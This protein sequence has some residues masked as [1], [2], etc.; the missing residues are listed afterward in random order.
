[1]D[2]IPK[3]M[4]SWKLE[5]VEWKHTTLKKEIIK[6]AILELKQ[7]WGG[8]SKDILIGSTSL[9]VAFAYLDLEDEYQIVCFLNKNVHKK[10]QTAQ[11]TQF[12]C[13]LLKINNLYWTSLKGP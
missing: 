7:S 13:E 12:L 4:Y 11:C 5:S 9:I 1:M 8:G 10:Y 6:E 3:I 2:D